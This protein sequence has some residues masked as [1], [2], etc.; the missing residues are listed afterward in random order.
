MLVLSTGEL[1]HGSQ[2]LKQIHRLRSAEGAE[3]DLGP[4]WGSGL[5]PALPLLQGGVSPCTFSSSHH[6]GCGPKEETDAEVKADGALIA[7][8]RIS[9][10]VCN[11]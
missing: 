6:L 1:S 2:K 9:I 3:S 5:C 11:V 8:F 10:K 7:S 4:S